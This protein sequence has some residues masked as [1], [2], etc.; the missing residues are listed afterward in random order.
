MVINMT[1]H[2]LIDKQTQQVCSF[3]DG[4]IS[5]LSVSPTQEFIQIPEVPNLPKPL[6][7]YR[8]A[9]GEFVHEPMFEYEDYKRRWKRLR[10]NAY[11][12]VTDYLD[13]LVKGDQAQMD[14]YIADCQAVKL[15]YPKPDQ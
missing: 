2:V 7:Y 11:P 8:F 15:R 6:N 10:A 14:K 13:G 3:A 4:D 5:T 9:D 12:V 1:I